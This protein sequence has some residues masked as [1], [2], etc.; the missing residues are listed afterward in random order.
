MGVASQ[1]RLGRGDSGLLCLL[2]VGSDSGCSE[3]D[4][5][6]HVWEQLVEEYKEEGWKA[7][8]VDPLFG[9]RNASITSISR[10][11][12]LLEEIE[13]VSARCF[14]IE[15]SIVAFGLGEGPFL[16]IRI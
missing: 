3:C 10:A 11:L 9:E 5:R 6:L 14:M 1:C 15:Y 4:G 13:D 8:C 2:D 7:A 12:T 16:R